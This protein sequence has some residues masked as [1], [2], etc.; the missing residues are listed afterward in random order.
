MSAPGSLHHLWLSQRGECFYCGRQTWLQCLR[1]SKL[2]RK[3]RVGLPFDATHKLLNT[4]QA[5][6]EHLRRKADGGTN[7]LDNLI[8][9]CAECN[10]SRGERPPLIHLANRRAL[11][12]GRVLAQAADEVA[13]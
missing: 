12:C 1:E 5:T 13:P 11:C 9:S 3:L 8:M 4:Y 2:Q 6:R 7:D 10:F